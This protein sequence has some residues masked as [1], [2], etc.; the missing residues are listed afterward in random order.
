MVLD[1][2]LPN[3]VKGVTREKRKTGKSKGISKDV[4]SGEQGTTNW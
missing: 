3:S 2:Y 4:G 1:R